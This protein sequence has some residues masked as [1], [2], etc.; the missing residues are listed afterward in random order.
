MS[1]S[2]WVLVGVLL[3]AAG[4]PGWFVFVVLSLPDGRRK[5]ESEE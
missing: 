2:E 3:V 1:A 5:K 4:L